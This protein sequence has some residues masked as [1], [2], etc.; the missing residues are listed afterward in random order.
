LL[1]R[2]LRLLLHSRSQ[3]S[4]GALIE[5]RR[6]D[7]GE[8]EIAETRLALA[9]V[10]R[11]TGLVVD[12]RELLPYQPVEQGRLADIGPADDGDRERHGSSQRILR[13]ACQRG[14]KTRINA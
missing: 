12:Q 4:P 13:H 8:G 9:A 14:E 5:P 11:H 3:G 7:D 10:A 6:I 2:A 1:D